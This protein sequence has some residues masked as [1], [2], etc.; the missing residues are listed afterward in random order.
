MTLKKVSTYEK[1]K[2]KVY[3]STQLANHKTFLKYQ[4]ENYVYIYGN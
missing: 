3:G 4:Q 1:K 2:S